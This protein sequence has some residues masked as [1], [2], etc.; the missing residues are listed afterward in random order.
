MLMIK[1]ETTII[2]FL[3]ISI[4]L[5]YLLTYQTTMA[6]DLLLFRIKKQEV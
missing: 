5:P 2:S 4:I 3:M 1:L 6:G